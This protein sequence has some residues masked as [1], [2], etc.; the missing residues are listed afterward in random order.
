MRQMF[1]RLLTKCGEYFFNRY[2]GDQWEDHVVLTPKPQLLQRG[3]LKLNSPGLYRLRGL[4][5][6]MGLL[7]VMVL[8][9]DLHNCCF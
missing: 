8:S 7:H 4:S 6:N 1:K 3:Y 5:E 9:Q 2:D